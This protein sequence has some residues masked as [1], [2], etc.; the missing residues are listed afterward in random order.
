MQMRGN[1][2]TA[3][4]G[5]GTLHA[6]HSVELRWYVMCGTVL[7]GRCLIKSPWWQEQARAWKAD[8]RYEHQ[9]H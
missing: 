2:A 9:L 5:D 4:V 1:K 8:I 7:F 3:S 6:P